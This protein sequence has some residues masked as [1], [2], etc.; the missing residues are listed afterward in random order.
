MTNQGVGQ[1][2]I[3]SVVQQL[4]QQ[5]QQ[6]EHRVATLEGSSPNHAPAVIT[7]LPP[8]AREKPP[9]TWRGFPPARK[10][11]GAIPVLGKAVLGIAGAYLLRAISESG[12]LPRLPVLLIAIVYAAFWMLWAIRTSSTHRF[13]SITYAITSAF[14]LSPMLWEA[15]VRFQALPPAFTAAVLVAFVVLAIALSWR[16]DLQFIPWIA[17]M[18]AVLTALALI[19]ETR[20]FVPFTAALLAIGLCAEILAALGHPTAVRVPPALAA[21]MSI[22]LLVL[23]MVSP[24][25]IGE[26][27]HLP[28][29]STVAILCFALLAIYAIAITLRSFWHLHQMTVMEI[30]QAVLAFAIAATGALLASRGTLA[31][32][33]GVLFLLLSAICYWGA[34]SRF[35]DE[36]QHRNR[37]VSATW[38][39]ALLVSGSLLLLPASLAVIFLCVAAVTSAYVY[40]RTGKFSLGLHTSLYLAAAAIVGPLPMYVVNALAGAVP[41]QPGWGVWLVALAAA[42]CYVMGAQRTEEKASRRILWL[43]PAVLA[44]FAIAAMAVAAIVFFAG[45]RLD[46]ASR[47][48]VIRTIVNCG[49]ALALGFF[50]SRWH[51]VELGWAAYIAVA[52]GTLKL[53]FE[54][55]RFGNAASLVISLLFY[56]LVLILLPRLTR[57]TEPE[58][59]AATEPAIK[60]ET[61]ADSAPADSAAAEP[62][63]IVG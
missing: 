39:A 2:D 49:L 8:I 63:S 12:A 52:F 58:A 7:A 20:D 32:F 48:S 18:A 14:I 24:Q 59:D 5:V 57:R 9:A 56:G 38:A 54:D 1:E 40:T 19:V 28:A 13:A 31:P 47:L 33:L 30:V 44:G 35:V 6:L 41:T 29:P 26:G 15:T 43:V 36:L 50:A 3:A 17:V 51:R 46:V 23:M 10:Q 45:H 16:R 21:D 55:L 61:K 37:R 34:L 60:A 62:V 27:F 53:L 25:G 4:R 11:S 42:L 22:A